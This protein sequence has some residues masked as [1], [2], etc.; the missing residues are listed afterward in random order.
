MSLEL[1]PIAF[2]Q[3][4]YQEC[5]GTPRQGALVPAGQGLLEL[6]PELR[7]QGFLSGLENFSHAW[8]LWHFHSNGSF[9][10]RGKIYPPRLDGEKT[11]LF[12]SRSPHR[13]N[14]IGLTLVRIEE[15]SGDTLR[16][17]GIDLI[18]GTPVFDIKPYLPET[19]YAASANASWTAKGNLHAPRVFFSPE[20]EAFLASAN[21]AIPAQQFRD[22]IAQSVAQ[23]PRPDTQKNKAKEFFFRL[24]DL[25]IGFLWEETG[26]VTIT[27]IRD[28]HPPV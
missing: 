14:P 22:L 24:Y 27:K 17:S 5:F 26:R 12:A 18:E 25:D 4:C 1:R 20:A 2:I 28:F 23:D 21:L 9:S 8:L 11:G 10:I 13:P 15:I 16:V 7:S 19:D 3:S 6:V